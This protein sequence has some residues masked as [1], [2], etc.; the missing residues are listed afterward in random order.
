LVNYS[1][2]IDEIMSRTDQRERSRLAE[3][4]GPGTVS[5]F[6]GPV[7]GAFGKVGTEVQ[8]AVRGS[9]LFCAKIMRETDGNL[10]REYTMATRINGN[11]TCPTVMP[12]LDWLS[13]P[14]E[15]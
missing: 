11:Q 4:G 5:L 12:V 14:G 10:Q 6:H 3:A 9:S 1:K 15:P 13:L 7:P 8:F 2:F